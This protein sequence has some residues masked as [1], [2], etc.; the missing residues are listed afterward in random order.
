[1]LSWGP[2]IFICE[3]SSAMSLSSEQTHPDIISSALLGPL[4]K[5]EMCLLTNS[6]CF[7]CLFCFAL[8]VCWRGQ[9]VWP[10]EQEFWIQETRFWNLALSSWLTFGRPKLPEPQ[11]P[12]IESRGGSAFFRVL[13]KI[14]ENRGK[15]PCCQAHKGYSIHGVIIF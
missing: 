1:M 9:L 2:C 4:G 12:C 11:F 14:R 7:S 6:D 10:I 13:E 3:N 5:K 8:Q 15:V